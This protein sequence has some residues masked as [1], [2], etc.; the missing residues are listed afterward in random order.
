MDIVV[1]K[2]DFVDENGV[3]IVYE[4]CRDPE[5]ELLLKELSDAV[6]KY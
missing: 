1:V 3:R 2:E 6:G 5:L 4:G